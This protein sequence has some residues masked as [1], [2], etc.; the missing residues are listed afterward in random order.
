MH[1]MIHMSLWLEKLESWCLSVCN[2]SSR[3]FARVV[4][5]YHVVSE[6]SL[7]GCKAELLVTVA[8]CLKMI[9]FLC[10]HQPLGVVAVVAGA[11]CLR[12]CRSPAPE[13]PEGSNCPSLTDTHTTWSPF[14]LSLTLTLSLTAV[15]QAVFPTLPYSC[16]FS[17]P[18][19]YAMLCI[20]VC[21]NMSYTIL[22]F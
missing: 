7:G 13:S 8:L 1:S 21:L 16:S 17:S 2:W 14:T 4:I 22:I 3:S 5:G 12:K 9:W 10:Q 19:G 15:L 11:P 20:M 6:V 18:S